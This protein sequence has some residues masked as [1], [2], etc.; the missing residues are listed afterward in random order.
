VKFKNPD[1]TLNNALFG[2]D[3]AHWS[4]LF[5]TDGSLEYGNDWKSNGDGTFTSVSAPK[6]Y[7]AL[8][9]YLMGMID[10]TWVPS[11]TLIQNASIDPTKLPEI[12]ATITGTAK[13]VTIDDIIA[14]E[15]ERLPNASTSQ[16]MF[17]TGFIF[18]TRPGTFT[19][20]E[21]PSIETLRN[22]WA[23]RFVSLTRGKG[24]IADVTPSLTVTIAS[25]SSGATISMPDVTVKGTIINSTGNETGMTVNGIVAMVSGNQF[26]AEHVPLAEGANTITVTATDTAGSTATSTITVNA[27][28]IGSYIRVTTNI[29]SG[30]APLETTLRVD[31]SFSITNSSINAT[32]P[33]SPEIT[34]ITPDEY[35]VKM[36][37]EGAYTFTISVTG[38][39]GN[40]YQNT[41]TITVQNRTQ[42]DKL[43]KAKWDGMKTALASQNITTALNYFN[44]ESKQLYNDMFTALNDQLPQLVQDMQDIQLIYLSNNVAKYRTKKYEI[45]GGQMMT[46][47]YYIYFSKDNNG[48]WKIYQ[49]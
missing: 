9:L 45:A 1:G 23:G 7:S 41:V 34:I 46:I 18:I 26:I 17:R 36:N 3:N 5:D 19:G 16:K 22:A 33:T 35:K 31:G 13:T 27:T 10:K 42:M 2:K 4:Y 11:M 25:P 48:I 32:G 8:D 28:T 6:Y 20:N 21:P 49:F 44:T 38:P 29:E 15:G 43:L 14:A 37:A 24:N 40:T 12:G 39:D 30:I 47:T